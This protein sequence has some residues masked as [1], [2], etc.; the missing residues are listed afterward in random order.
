LSIPPMSSFGCCVIKP[1]IP[2]IGKAS[3]T[4]SR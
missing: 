2:H 4:Q 1:V 3:L